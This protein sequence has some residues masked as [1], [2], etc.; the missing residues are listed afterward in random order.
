MIS[1]HAIL[2]HPTHSKDGTQ[3]SENAR[4]IDII[5]NG[6]LD[7]G[8]WMSL[9]RCG[10]H[11]E[12]CALSRKGWNADGGCLDDCSRHTAIKS[13]PKSLLCYLAESQLWGRGEQF[14]APVLKLN[15]DCCFL[16]V[17]VIGLIVL[18][19]TSWLI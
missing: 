10:F 1:S 3:V 5:E 6:G 15:I 2:C 8:R 4:R 18:I 11:K 9:N 13:A 17:G 14:V 12:Q 19:F 7:G 16:N